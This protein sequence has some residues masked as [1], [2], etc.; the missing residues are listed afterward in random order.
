MLRP[1]PNADAFLATVFG[2][3]EAQDRARA[4]EARPALAIV[5]DGPVRW[6]STMSDYGRFYDL[7]T[8]EKREIARIRDKGF[9]TLEAVQIVVRSRRPNAEA[10]R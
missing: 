10:S 5:T 2:A 3:A 7:T 9:T 6:R 1:V 8:D 4:A